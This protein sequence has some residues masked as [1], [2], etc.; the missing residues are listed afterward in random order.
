VLP[1]GGRLMYCLVQGR[2]SRVVIQG[3]GNQQRHLIPIPQSGSLATGFEVEFALAGRFDAAAESIR[4]QWKS[5]RLAIPV[6]TFPEFRDDPEFGISVSRNRWSVYVPETWQATMVDDPEVTN[7]M[8]A[9]STE[10]EDASLLSEVEQAVSLLKSVKS[11]KGNYARG[12]ALIEVQNA[13]ERLGRNLGKDSGVEQQRGE[14]LGKLS[15]I[16]DEYL[17]Q[18]GPPGSGAPEPIIIGNGFLFEQDYGQNQANYSNSQLFFESNGRGLTPLGGAQPEG[19]PETNAR[20][21]FG[22]TIQSPEEPADGESL[23]KPVKKSDS[24]KSGGE[25]PRDRNVRQD[26]KRETAKQ[27]ADVQDGPAGNQSSI[28]SQLLQRRSGLSEPGKSPGLEEALVPQTSPTDESAP[29]PQMAFPQQ[30]DDFF[31][32]AIPPSASEQ[33]TAIPTG[34]LSLKFDIPSDGQRVDFLRVGGNPLLSMDVRSAEAVSKGIGLI[35]LV[36]CGLGILMLLGPGRRGE[37]FVFFQRLFLILA[38]AG[39]IFWLLSGSNQRDAGLLICIFAAIGLA[40]TF[41]VAQFRKPMARMK[42]H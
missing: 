15:E 17:H 3:E 19:A 38:V 31:G 37:T 24:E 4:K 13:T 10:L 2:P 29:E 6:P 20:F 33:K 1:V 22:I 23:E 25:K 40:V 9:E 34:L 12:R 42:N 5:S 41:I 11:A 36:I 35:W 39:L 28:R 21:R 27:L 14:V 32:A 30:L 26:V 8:K 7:V 16:N 18:A